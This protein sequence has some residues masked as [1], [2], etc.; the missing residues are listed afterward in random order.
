MAFYH[1]S[2]KT[3]NRIQVRQRSKITHYATASLFLSRRPS[4][5]EQSQGKVKKNNTE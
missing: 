5:T 2:A 3:A 1:F 4:A